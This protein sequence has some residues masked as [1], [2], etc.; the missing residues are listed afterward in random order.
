MKKG[1]E[2]AYLLDKADMLHKQM[3]QIFLKQG[4]TTPDL[5]LLSSEDKEEWDRLYEYS[6]EVSDKVC[7]LI[8]DSNEI[9]MNEIEILKDQI[10][11]LQTA[12]IAKEETHRIEIEELKEK[13]LNAFLECDGYDEFE[14]EI[15]S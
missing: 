10:E 7:K 8:N 5:S 4:L 2:L 14:R 9:N 15:N 1:E 12:L 13:A 11:S 3:N 6:K